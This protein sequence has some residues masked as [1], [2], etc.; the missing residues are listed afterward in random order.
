[1][2]K[3]SALARRA[4]KSHEPSGPVALVTPILNGVER[5]VTTAQ[6]AAHL[7]VTTRTIAN[8]R[9]KDY[10]LLARKRSPNL[11]SHQR[12][13][14]RAL[15]QMNSLQNGEAR[16]EAPIPNP[17]SNLSHTGISMERQRTLELLCLIARSLCVSAIHSSGRTIWIADAHR[18]DGKRFIVRADEKL[19]AFVELETAI[20]QFAVDA[21]S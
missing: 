3:E 1:M 9:A 13:R 18:D 5:P 7:Q 4:S 19:T 21:M 8:Y 20:H 15:S 14:T 16:R 10:P 17:T 2:A 6:L 11:V 12:C